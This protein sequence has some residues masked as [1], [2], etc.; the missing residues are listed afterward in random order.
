MNARLFFALTKPYVLRPLFRFLRRFNPIWPVGNYLVVSRYLDLVEVMSRDVEF[1]ISQV[2]GP[3]L[4]A[5]DGPFLL[6]LDRGPQYDLEA[7]MVHNALPCSDLPRI[8]QIVNEEATR[9]IQAAWPARRIDLVNGYARVVTVRLIARHFG[10]PVDDEQTMAGWL[11]DIFWAVFLDPANDPAI[12]QQAVRSDAEL[13]VYLEKAIADH[14]A[15]P[16]VPPADVVGK[17]VAFQ[18]A[19]PGLD[20][21]A[22]R[23][24][25]GGMIVGMVDNTTTFLTYALSELLRNPRQFARAREAALA[26][27]RDT[28][29]RYIYEAGRFYPV[30]T[31]LSRHANV[32]TIIAKGTR[33]QRLVAAGTTVVLGNISAMFD[34]D[35]FDEPETFD[36]D[37]DSERLHFGFGLHRCSGYQINSVQIPELAAG[38]LRLSNLRLA[39]GRDGKM[40]F[41]GPFPNRLLLDFD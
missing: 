31:L 4:N 8:A 40:Q 27:D 9:Q 23:R 41:Q 39:P 22:I 21:G 6:G 15:A 14:R 28:V 19:N 10:V 29:R 12:M 34:A 25:L 20:Q 13:R 16:V 33:R 5:I 7:A 2:N 24:N 38:L 30:A 36:I 32:D 37:H 18:A 17:M 1:T 26:G 11:R 35:G 3:K